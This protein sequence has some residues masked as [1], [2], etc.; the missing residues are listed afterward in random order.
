MS[1]VEFG[2]GTAYLYVEAST[3]MLSGYIFWFILSHFTSNEVIGTS[4]TVISLTII[5]ISIVTIGV[6]SG[7]QRYLGKSF[8]E[9]K[10]RN[11]KVF[12]T[13][14]LLIVITGTIIS[15]FGMFLVKDWISYDFHVDFRLFLLSILI[16]ASSAISALLR[17]IVVASLKTRILYVLSIISSI[18][19]VLLALALVLVGLGAIGILIGYAFPTILT[20]V[21]LAYVILTKFNTQTN[22]SDIGLAGSLKKVLV[23]SIAFW[24]PGLVTTIGSQLGTIVVFG[25]QGAAQAGVYFI[26][27]SIVTGISLITSALTTISYPTISALSDGR[28]RLAWRL[29]RMTLLS[30]FPLSASFIFYS[31]DIMQIFGRS[32]AGGAT[33]LELLLL[34][35]LPGVVI[36]G[37]G[38][39]VYSYGKNREVLAIGLAVSIPRT[40]LYFVFVPHMGGLGAA[41]SYI[42][43]SIIGFIVSII[44]A[45][46]VKMRIFWKDLAFISIIPAGVAFILSTLGLNYIFGVVI[47]LVVSYILYLRL[48]ILNKTDIEDAALL[49]PT[50]IANPTVNLLYKIAKD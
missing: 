47:T 42:V 10:L 15:S 25:S 36:G 35:L 20:S 38:V 19:K 29:A 27:L 49:L 22:E 21:V 31:K 28:K 33:T 40:L 12:T 3:M 50:R 23:A 45:K 11:V 9:Q 1:K 41:I 24:V 8:F 34:S 5:F 48:K 44:I 18:A 16:I 37:V 13:A 30:T 43:G 14:S 4:S 17:S 26:A 6:P 39:L 46:D 7:V 32:Y 2:K